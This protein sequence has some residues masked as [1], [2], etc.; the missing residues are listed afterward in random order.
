MQ[1]H[2]D[3]HSYT[4][5]QRHIYATNVHI[6]MYRD[7]FFMGIFL[8]CSKEGILISFGVL[9]VLFGNRW[10]F[11]QKKIAFPIILLNKHDGMRFTE[12]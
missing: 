11:E 3:T 9:S 1:R 2:T 8:A 10:A 6:L 4:H 5:A 7:M 12:I